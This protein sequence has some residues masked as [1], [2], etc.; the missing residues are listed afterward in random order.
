MGKGGKTTQKVVQEIPPFLQNQLTQ[1]YNLASDIQPAVF[2]GERVAG[3]NP[4]QT[5]AQQLTADRA[6]AGNPTVQQAQNLLGG[7]ISSDTQPTYAESFLGDIAR[8]QS[9]TNPFLQTQIN[10]A[11]SGAANQATSQYALGG[12]LGSSAFGT[13]LGEGITGAAAPILAQQVEA[14]RAAQM[15]AAGQLISAE[16]QNRDLQMQAAQMAPTL[17]QQDFLNLQALSDVGA[18]QQLMSQAQIQA[19]QDFINE[20]NAAQMS[21]LKSL[22]TATGLAPSATNSV[23]TGGQKPGTIDTIS[24]LGSTAALMAM[25]FS[26]ERMKENINQIEDPIKKVNM[27]DGVTFNYKGQPQQSAGLL[28]QDVERVLPMAVAEQ[29]NGMKAVNYAQVTGLLTEAVK[30]LSRKV[31]MLEARAV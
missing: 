29:D 8:G 31:N 17:A 24:Q 26:D 4:L 22:A 2:A 3:F 20:L 12:R 25:A 30:D 19:Q 15:Q 1:T 13:A 7:I 5:L 18:Q 16:Q 27:L 9:P 6:L 10:N 11:I 21:K 28:A 14:D 23:T